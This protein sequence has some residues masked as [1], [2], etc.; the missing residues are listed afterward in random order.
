MR[1]SKL[2][3]K[4]K[5][6]FFDTLK[7]YLFSVHVVEGH[8]TVLVEALGYLMSVPP[9]WPFTFCVHSTNEIHIPLG[10]IKLQTGFYTLNAPVGLMFCNMFVLT[11]P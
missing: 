3:F 4:K 11:M 8:G 2:F 5:I 10:I 7:K 1:T 9:R 6:N